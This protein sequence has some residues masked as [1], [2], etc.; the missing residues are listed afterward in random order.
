ME[1]VFCPVFVYLNSAPPESNNS[2]SI[3]W[4]NA[5]QQMFK[6]VKSWPYNF[7]QS[8]DFP[9]SDQRGSLSCRLLVHDR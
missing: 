9:S 7:T 4:N 5:K 6:E 2:T 3:L 1:K 8:Q